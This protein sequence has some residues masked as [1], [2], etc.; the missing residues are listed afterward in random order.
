MKKIIYEDK[1]VDAYDFLM[2]KENALEIMSGK[3]KLE[4]RSFTPKYYK[5]LIDREQEAKNRENPEEYILPIRTDI[6][7]IHF[8][9]YNNSWFLN[10]KIKEIGLAMMDKEEIEI[11]AEEFD[12]HDYDN[13][14]QKF[15]K[16]PNAQKPM[17]FWFA[18]EKIIEHNVNFKKNE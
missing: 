6:S 18:I 5:L 3:K 10:V 7:F 11:L 16:L 15:E 13:E 9:N 17:F 4:I 2:K 1:E 8:H 14:W 12:F